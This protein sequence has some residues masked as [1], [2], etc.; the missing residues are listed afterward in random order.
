[1][2]GQQSND[3]DTIASMFADNEEDNNHSLPDLNEEDRQL[4]G[5]MK[6]IRLDCDYDEAYRIK[7]EVLEKTYHKMFNT[8]GSSGAGNNRNPYII[9]FS[10]AASIAVLLSISNIYMYRMA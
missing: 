9:L 7:N 8:N 1:M 6:N 4:L 10:I 3:W 2:D 5:I